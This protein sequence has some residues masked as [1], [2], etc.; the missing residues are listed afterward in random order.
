MATTPLP[1]PIDPRSL[2][3]VEAVFLGE[4][5]RASRD[6]AQRRLQRV[7]D[8]DFSS[9]VC[10]LV[11]EL[12]RRTVAKGLHPDAEACEA[13]AIRTGMVPDRHRVN[14]AL[15]L[16]DLLDLP[17]AP[18]DQAVP[19]VTAD[20]TDAA[21]RRRIREHLERCIQLLEEAGNDEIRTAMPNEL[22]AVWA[23][24]QRLSTVEKQTQLRR[25]EV[26]A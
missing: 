1:A 4:L 15:L 3:T 23:Q 14:L 13:L 16:V 19:V 25:L 2:P 20:L 17:T 18:R 26:V 10:R 11:L 7:Q 5:L 12:V 8:E 22:R 6:T 21:A 24:S 9:P